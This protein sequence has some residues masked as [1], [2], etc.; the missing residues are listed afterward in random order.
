MKK[1]M[2][3]TRSMEMDLVVAGRKGITNKQMI[4]ALKTIT[5]TESLI[6]L[7]VDYPE[8]FKSSIKYTPDET[9]VRLEKLVRTYN[10]PEFTVVTGKKIRD[11]KTIKAEKKQKKVEQK[12]TIIVLE[13]YKNK[14]NAKMANVAAKFQMLS[15][16]EQAIVKEMVEK[17]LGIS[18]VA[19]LHNLTKD[20]AYNKIFRSKSSIY[21][22]LQAA[23]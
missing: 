2:V 8:V 21:N 3:I 9:K 4:E 23:N 20:Q 16:E 6:Q 5:D 22:R 1:V 12:P 14:N 7:L 17:D 13:S 11:G 18:E 15:E 19:K 10:D